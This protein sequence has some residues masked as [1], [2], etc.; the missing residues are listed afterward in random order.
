MT[1]K[2]LTMFLLNTFFLV[3]MT[4]GQNYGELTISFSDFDFSKR[5]N[6]IILLFESE[7]GF[8]DEIDKANRY[9]ISSGDFL[10]K[11]S[12]TIGHVEYGEYAVVA[13]Y[14]KNN[15]EKLD[16]NFVGRPTEPL[17]T[18]ASKKNKRLK[19]K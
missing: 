10:G 14:D 5:D 16:V 15:N 18:S 1:N 6:L 4:V 17:G 8:P 12:T 2:S 9:S 13:Y 19:F 3:N 11:G 7:L